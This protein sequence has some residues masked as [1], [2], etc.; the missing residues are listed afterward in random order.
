MR[1]SI[2][3]QVQEIFYKSGINKIGTSKH[4]AKN[5]AK[6]NLASDRLSP[7]WH[8]IGKQIG[9]HS[10]RTADLYRAIWDQVG[11]YV[12]AEFKVKDLEK[13]EPH[14]IKS[15]LESKVEKGLAHSTFSQHASALEKFESALNGFAQEKGTG[16]V[17]DFT[18]SINSVRKEAHKTLERFRD[19]RAY[20]DPRALI[21][22][23][24]DDNH[25][26][27]AKIQLESG[28]RVSECTN[29]SEKNL[30]GFK[31]D[32][33][34]GEEKGVIYIEKAKGGKCGKKYMAKETYK[35]L[36][37][38]IKTSAEGR[39]VV[40]ND[41]YRAGLKRAAERTDQRY[42]GAHG[43]RWNFAQERFKEVQ[44]EGGQSYTQALFQVSGELFHARADITEHY[45]KY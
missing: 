4:N 31:K 36:E 35:E 9:I 40:N 1:G 8:R 24:R 12:K 11:N 2:N 3:W 25:K 26:L 29:L 33:V 18:E 38:K 22:A 7:T 15:Y 27:T 45:L 41:S 6:Q 16:K 10:Y 42:T 17:Y 32:P 37:N 28:C 44:G 5:I 43:L 21:S 19:T 20:D 13:I 14:H 23:I 39:F 34:T 30:V